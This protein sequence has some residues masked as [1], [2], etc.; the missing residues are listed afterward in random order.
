VN[1][2]EDPDATGRHASNRGAGPVEVVHQVECV[3]EPDD[4]DHAQNQVNA[5]AT[6]RLPSQSGRDEGDRRDCLGDQSPL[7]R[8][9]HSIIDGAQER[10]AQR[11]SDRDEEA[12]GHP[13]DRSRRNQESGQHGC[14]SEER[15]GRSVLAVASG[16][17]VEVRST[18]DPKRNRRTSKRCGSRGGESDRR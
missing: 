16:P 5:V 6:A 2:R 11:A 10:Q 4:P 7:W 18:S 14:A 1:R 17:V 9:A 3:D 8:H 13:A 12:P 15:S